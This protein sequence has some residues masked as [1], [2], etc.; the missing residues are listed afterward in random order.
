MAIHL[1]HN[2]TAWEADT[3]DMLRQDRQMPSCEILSADRGIR[4][5]NIM[6]MS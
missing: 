2:Q 3:N 5:N 6:P 1:R 4:I